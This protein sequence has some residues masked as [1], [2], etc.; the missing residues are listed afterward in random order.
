VDLSEELENVIED[1]RVL[2]ADARLTIDAQVQPQLRVQADRVLLH[3]AMFNLIINAIKYNEPEGSI[4]LTLTAT[5]RQVI[6]TVC[7]S[8]LGIPAE[9]HPL[10]FDRFYR[11]AR[12]GR[13]RADGIGLGLSLAREIVRAH[14]GELALKESHAGRTC[15]ELRLRQQA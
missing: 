8:G 7:N 13:P 12:A 2:A 15:F 6:L 10:I 4:S 14:C 9:D 11:V 5:D 1:A 3:T